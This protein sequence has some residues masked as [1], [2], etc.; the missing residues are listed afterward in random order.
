MENL[1]EE[2]ATSKSPMLEKDNKSNEN[3]SKKKN[4]IE[5]KYGE[6]RDPF[7][8]KFFGRLNNKKERALVR[9]NLGKLMEEPSYRFRCCPWN[10]WTTAFILLSFDMLTTYVLYYT[11]TNSAY[12]NFVLSLVI[13]FYILCFTLLYQ[14]E[15]EYF[16]INRKKAFIKKSKVNIF[17][18]KIDRV[19][20]FNDIDYFQMVMKGVKKGA[21]D[22][23]KY[24]IRV[25]MK[26]KETKPIEWGYTWHF[27][28]ISFKYQVC[29]AMVKGI[30]IEKVEDYLV[31][32]EA[33]YPDYMH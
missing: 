11:Y 30:V 27:D 7:Y 32:D 14:G 3:K 22:N 31:K 21:N 9:Q 18:S 19:E 20:Y 16:T 4:K 28:S 29:L 17:G 2:K 25:Y 10:L 5:S 8:R 1:K 12:N 26:D 13:I 33:F 15:I 24:F 23:R 6:S